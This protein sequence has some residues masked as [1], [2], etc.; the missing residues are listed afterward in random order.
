MMNYVVFFT[1]GCLLC[2]GLVWNTSGIA[3]VDPGFRQLLCVF[4][5]SQRSLVSQEMEI[6]RLNV[7]LVLSRTQGKDSERSQPESLPPDTI[8]SFVVQESSLD[9]LQYINEDI[10]MLD[11]RINLYSTANRQI[12]GPGREIGGSSADSWFTCTIKHTAGK[13]TTTAFLMHNQKEG[14][15]RNPGHLL[16]GIT[17]RLHV[18]VPFLLHPAPTHVHT[19]L[20]RDVWMP[21]AFTK[22]NPVD[23]TIQWVLNQKG[24]HRKHLFTYSGSSKQVEHMARRVKMVLE[25][26]PKGNASLLLRNTEIRDEGTYSCLVSMGSL[27][28]EQRIQLQIEEKPIVTVNVDSL[29]LVEGEQHKL[30]C[31]I[32]HYYP[33]DVEA[34][35]LREPKDS[36]RV[37]YVLKNVLSSSHQQSSNGT[38]S[39]S[40][41]FLLTASLNDNGHK[42]TCLVDHQS[43]QAPIRKSV[44][45][46]VKEATPIAWLLLLLSLTVCLAGTLWYYHKVRSTNKPKPY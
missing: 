5:T 30:V 17:E 41:Y 37:P 19:A 15:N 13:Y 43:L 33:H 46:E 3:T 39:S 7:R 25:E 23:V 36:Q 1:A 42:Y 45:V 14:E 12:I 4:E 16:P 11:C 31:S 6:I 34:Q 26:I 38:Y 9:I 27:T 44:T 35:W 20:T 8:P 28:G 32:R 24:G 21:C 40:R 18:S 2:L 29:S 22:N 10:D